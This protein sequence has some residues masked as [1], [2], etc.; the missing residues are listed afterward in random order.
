MVGQLGSLIHVFQISTGDKNAHIHD[1]SHRIIQ[2]AIE[3]N[4]EIKECFSERYG[5]AENALFGNYGRGKEMDH[6]A[7]KLGFYSSP[8]SG[9]LQRKG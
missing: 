5:S 8:I 9:I 2:Q 1:Q 7:K 6:E 4:D 3:E